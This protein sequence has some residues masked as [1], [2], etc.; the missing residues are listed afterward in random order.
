MLYALGER[1]VRCDS[2]AWFVAHNAVV[3][4]SVR[5]GDRASV[6][7]GS[8]VRGDNDLITIGAD[9]N[10]QDGAVLHTDEG[11]PLTIGRGVT[12]GHQ[13]MLHGCTIGDNSLIGIQA[14]ILNQAVIGRNCLIGAGALITEGKRIP[15]NSLV[16]GSPGRVVRELNEREIDQLRHAA[17][18]YVEKAG[19]YRVALQA[20][21]SPVP[22]E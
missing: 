10:V 4:G 21:D 22:V 16:M 17:A 12:I 5:L 11:I 9:S 6:W 3:I 19:Q 1:K 20:Q 7:F 2:D 8:T 15:D 14:V 18:H 13:V